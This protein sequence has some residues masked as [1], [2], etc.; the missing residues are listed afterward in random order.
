MDAYIPIEEVLIDLRA[1]GWDSQL[2]LVTDIQL[3]EDLVLFRLAD[4]SGKF[5]KR[6]VKLKGIR[7]HDRIYINEYGYKKAKD[8]H[9]K[10]N[11]IYVKLLPLCDDQFFQKDPPR[12]TPEPTSHPMIISSTHYVSDEY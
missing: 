2:T 7:I 8:H 10:Y 9:E 1:G 3:F 5:G 11:E 4:P 6:D 12:D